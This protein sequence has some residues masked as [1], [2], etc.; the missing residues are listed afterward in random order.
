MPR[1]SKSGKA[2]LIVDDDEAIRMVAEAALRQHDVQCASSG[3][4]A[5]ALLQ[6]REFD[7]VL[8]DLMMPGM[9]GGE[10]FEAVDQAV[11]D[12]FIFM[13]G[14]SIPDHVQSLLS[15]CARPVLWKPFTIEG[16]R[17]AVGAQ[18]AGDTTSSDLD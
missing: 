14:G 8:C 16:I 15:R 5:K 6:E 2:V 10:L 4:E 1:V 13:S 9:T 12:R 11:R 17:Q 18:L 3:V 7:V